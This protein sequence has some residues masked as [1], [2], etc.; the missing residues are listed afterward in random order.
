MSVSSVLPSSAGSLGR[1]TP[2]AVRRSPSESPSPT[3][4]PLPP[5]YERIDASGKGSHYQR[6]RDDPRT[7]PVSQYIYCLLEF[8]VGGEEN[9]LRL[10][11]DNF[12]AARCIEDTTGWSIKRFVRT[13]GLA[14]GLICP[15]IPAAN[16]FPPAAFGRESRRVATVGIAC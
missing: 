6:R 2:G 10:L 1:A 15:R 5:L 13:M 11:I 4:D 16:P 12:F 14:I 7:L 9:S 3:P 8:G